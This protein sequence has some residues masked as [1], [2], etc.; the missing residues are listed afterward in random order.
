MS[1]TYNDLNCDCACVLIKTSRLKHCSVKISPFLQQ[2]LK[3]LPGQVHQTV[4]LLLSAFEVLNAK[5]VHCHLWD[6]QM[7]AP[8]Q[9]LQRNAHTLRSSQ[10]TSDDLSQSLCQHTHLCQFVETLC[11]TILTLHVVNVSKPSVPVH[12]E[13]HVLG[14]RP[15]LRHRKGQR[16]TQMNTFLTGKWVHFVK[17]FIQPILYFEVQRPEPLRM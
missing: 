3:F 16:S 13:G 6:V 2:P 8:A 1:R 17:S 12:D 14:H 4:H 10:M 5:G 15:S 7:F 11:V 9:S